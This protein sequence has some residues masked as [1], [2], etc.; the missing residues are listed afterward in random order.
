MLGLN[1]PRHQSWKAKGYEHM[2]NLRRRRRR[3]QEQCIL[4]RQIYEEEEELQDCSS[5]G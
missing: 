2:I 5:N 4:I 3:R 1:A